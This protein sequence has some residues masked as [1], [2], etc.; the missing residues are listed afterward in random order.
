M[1]MKA[2]LILE[3]GQF[4]GGHWSRGYFNRRSGVQYWY[5]RISRLSPILRS[6]VR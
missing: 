6:A 1:Q 4:T 5:D 3:D 2:I